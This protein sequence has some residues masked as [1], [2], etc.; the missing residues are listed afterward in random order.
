MARLML[1]DDNRDTLI[2]LDELLGA[3]GYQ[4]AGTATSGKES[5]EMA[6]VLDPDLVLM[7]IVMPGAMDGVAAAETIKKELDIPSIFITGYSDDEYRSRAKVADPY[8]YIVKPFRVEDVETAIEI[9]LQKEEALCKLKASEA[10]FSAFMDNLKAFAYIKDQTGNV[11]FA[12]R[13]MQDFFEG[14]DLFASSP[15]DLLTEE[16][17][18]RIRELD[19]ETLRSG[20]QLHIDTTLDRNGIPHTFQTIKFLIPG[21]GVSDHIGN[22]AM[23]ITDLVAAQDALQ[24]SNEALETAVAQRTAELAS[25]N[26]DLNDE[27]EEHRSSR[28]D[29]VAN[30][31]L[32]TN[33]NTA[34]NVV[35]EKRDEDLIKIQN[36]VKQKAET[37]MM[38]YL[39]SLKTGLDDEDQKDLVRILELNLTRMISPAKDVFHDSSSE[40]SAKERM[41]ADYVSLGKSG[42]EI[43]VLMDLSP[44]T[45]ASYRYNLREKLGIKNRRTR[46]RE[47]LLGR[48]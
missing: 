44:T 37:T 6:R 34:L 24:A 45:V 36:R 8:G 46:L 20:S 16:Q 29:L 27:I 12:N 43:A 48:T 11:L 18:D 2:L 3:A 17:A 33:T 35:L 41:V 26:E 40:F 31:A 9:A 7:D 30:A 15:D 28:A 1:V 13:E 21:N 42:K 39:R 47:Y 10:K 22:L 5:V 38:P 14:K 4:I 23:D 19:T 25:T 32:L